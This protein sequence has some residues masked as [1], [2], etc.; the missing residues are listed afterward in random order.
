MTQ[1]E[2]TP[3]IEAAQEALS[4]LLAT[5]LGED[6]SLRA[7]PPDEAT[8]D[9][10]L[11]R[12]VAACCVVQDAARGMTV[13]L[14][15]A[16]IS[17]LSEAML[18]EAMSAAD[19]GAADLVGEV[20]AQGFGTVQSTLAAGGLTLSAASFE[21]S[22]PGQAL[23]LP[24]ETL[25]RIPFAAQHGRED[26]SGFVLLPA[27]SPGA[28]QQG[29]APAAAQPSARPPAQP[30]AGAASANDKLAEAVPAAG[31]APAAFADLGQE[32]LG[33]DGAGPGSFG[34]LAEVNLEVTVEL[35]RRR[36]PLSDL[37]KLTT[38]SVIELEKLVGEP[39]EVYANGR[40]IAEGEAVVID[41]Q[42]GVRITNLASKTRRDRA[43]F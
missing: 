8:P 18:G 27:P 33:G 30:A 6:L 23:D 17:L 19:E 3:H 13:A 37:L 11:R 25:L 26:L 41:E 31:L 9:E 4:T 42:F 5:L 22:L 21:V 14:S 12:E 1:T 16:W 24:E 43:F 29:A 36:L 7:A 32:N 39:L 40:L 2:L 35:G 38:G 10:A 20:A 34:F 15:P 28:K